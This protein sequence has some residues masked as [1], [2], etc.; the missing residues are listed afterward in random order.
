MQNSIQSASYHTMKA[1][2]GGSLSPGT[3]GRWQS[4]QYS[5]HLPNQLSRHSWWKTWWHPSPRIWAASSNSSRH[6]MHRTFVKGCSGCSFRSLAAQSTKCSALMLLSSFSIRFLR[7]CS[8]NSSLS[9]VHLGRMQ[10]INRM[11]AN[12]DGSMIATTVLSL[13]IMPPL[14]PNC[15]KLDMFDD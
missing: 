9:P 8:F 10:A 15:V 1:I 13:P 7:R 12:S 6:M 4:G 5:F 14:E 3:I 11:R 2:G